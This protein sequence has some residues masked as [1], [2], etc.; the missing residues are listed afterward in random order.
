MKFA[1]TPVNLNAAVVHDDNVAIWLVGGPEFAMRCEPR[2]GYDELKAI[3]NAKQDQAVYLYVNAL[4]E[5]HDL[6]RLEQYLEKISTFGFDGVVFQDLAVYQLTKTRNY[7]WKLVYHPDTLNTNYASLNQY[8]ALGVSG[9]FL[10]REIPLAEKLAINAEVELDTFVQ[11]HGSEY[12][13]YSKRLLVSNYAKVIDQDL[14]TAKAAKT[15]ILASNQPLADYVYED[16]FGTH[17]MSKTQLATIDIIDQF[18]PFDY[19]IIDN[20]FIGNDDYLAVVELYCQA[21]SETPDLMEQLLAVTPEIDYY[22]SFTFAGTVYKLD[23]V[24]RID[25]A[26]NSK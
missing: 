15:V 24:R 12:L 26:K 13:A 22:K 16:E 17:V 10:A 4:I 21:L 8:Q 14:K 9:A 25:D 1:I 20:Q 3:I 7:D 6:N 11:V 18:K 2:F 19:G 23:D 5:E